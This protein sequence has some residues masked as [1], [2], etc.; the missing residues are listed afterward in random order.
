MSTSPILETSPAKRRILLCAIGMSPQIVT[1]TL[2]ALAVRPA[3]GVPRWVPTE[4]HIITTALGAQNARLTLLSAYPGWFHQLRR[5]YDLPPIAFDD[6]HIHTICDAHGAALDDIRTPGDN[7]SAADQIAALVRDLTADPGSTLHASLAGGRKTMSYY[8]GY[9]LSLYGRAQD[10]LSH[11]LVSSDYE[12]HPDFFYPTRGQRIIHTREPHPRA[13]DCRDAQV[14]LAEI[15]FLRLRDTQPSH[16][17]HTG[18]V[19]LREAVRLANL[20][21]EPAVVEVDELRQRIT[22]SGV[23][24]Q[25]TETTFAYYAWLLSRHKE[26]QGDVDISDPQHAQMF[27]DFVKS[28]FGEMAEIYERIEQTSIGP[29]IRRNDTESLKGMFATYRTRVNLQLTAALGEALA[30]RCHIQS[31]GKRGAMRYDLPEDLIVR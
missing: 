10:R 8:L 4:V 2:Y 20:A 5:D 21:Q 23:P 31:H 13:L 19:S 25:L 28:R 26:G 24:V 16:A 29:S 1:E 11:V 3:P 14:Q 12:A 30:R 22:V 7:E 18:T 15:P 17:L 6:A 27:L 9:A